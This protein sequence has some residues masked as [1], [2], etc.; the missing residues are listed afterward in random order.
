MD[1]SNDQ[2]HFYAIDVFCYSYVANP[3]GYRNHRIVPK[4]AGGKL[5]VEKNLLPGN[6]R[7]EHKRIPTTKNNAVNLPGSVMYA[8]IRNP[9]H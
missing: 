2:P 4:R 7:A 1:I 3:N 9:P 5:G 8:R 6:Q